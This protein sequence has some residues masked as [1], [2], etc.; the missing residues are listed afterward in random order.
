MAISP[1][2]LKYS[3]LTLDGIEESLDNKLKRG[4]YKIL[5]KTICVYEHD[6]IHFTH[7][8]LTSIE[9]RYR[10]AGWRVAVILYYGEVGYV[11]HLS[12]D[13]S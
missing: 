11:L 7:E 10:Q 8:E 6:L 5:G 9:N 3:K 1:K 4:E 13:N 12:L 2:D